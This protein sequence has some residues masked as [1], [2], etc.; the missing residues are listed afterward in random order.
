[1]FF[2]YFRFLGKISLSNFPYLE[3]SSLNW[4]DAFDL[5]SQLTEEECTLMDS[6]REYCKDKLLPRVTQAFRTEEFDPTVIPEM[7]QMGLLGAPYQGY[8]CAGTSFVGYGLIAREI[9]RIDSGYR[10][11]FS[12]QTS[13]VISPIYRFGTEEQKEKYIPKLAAG[14]KIGCFGLTEPNHGSDPAGMETKAKWDSIKKAY[15]LS[16]TKSWISNSP[17]ADIFIVWAR[18]ERHNNDVMG[19]ILEK[20][21]PRLTAPKIEG[22]LSLRTSIT[23]Q[24]AMDEV[25]VPEENILPKIKGLAGPFD[26]LNNARLGIAW[27]VLGSAEE[28]FHISR[29]YALDR[30]QFGRPL[31]KNQLIQ[32]KF[33]D[34]LTEITLGLQACLRVTRLKDAKKVVPE[35]ISLI[36]RNNCMK[37]LDISRKAR[38]ILGGNGIVDEYHVM[39]HLVN[40][41]TVNTYEG[42]HDIH[43]LI[44][45]RSITGLQAFKA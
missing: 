28:C 32:L 4:Q 27:G 43:A 14:E 40:L 31:A 41:E 21:M 2:N 15:F 1:M 6:T 18:S 26:C 19:F 39:R 24:I 9:E 42:T 10:S 20:G 30:P 45:G 11:A 33:A 25:E 34:M 3:A 5:R 13:L 7:G 29:Q 16:G 35:Q 23:G 22:K 37:A 17:V 44:L 12:V 36:K 8:G 38:D